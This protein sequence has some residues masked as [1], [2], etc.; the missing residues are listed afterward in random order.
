MIPPGT[1]VTGAFGLASHVTLELAP[2][3]VVKGSGELSDY[4]LDGKRTGLLYTKDAEHVSIV[5]QGTIDGNGMQFMSDSCLHRSL[6]GDDPFNPV[7][8][9]ANRRGA[10]GTA[11]RL[12]VL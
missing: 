11:W 12:L 5:G 2:G 6:P 4:E 8:I 7:C 1:F 9:W 3:G 10:F